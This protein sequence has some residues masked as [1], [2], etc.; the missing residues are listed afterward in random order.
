MPD[1]PQKPAVA[2]KSID[3]AKPFES[4]DL[5]AQKQASSRFIVRMSANGTDWYECPTRSVNFIQRV[6]GKT[7]LS[8]ITTM[9]KPLDVP[10]GAVATFQVIRRSDGS[11]VRGDVFGNVTFSHVAGDSYEFTVSPV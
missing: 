8:F 7:Q 6:S 4:V 5:A 2:A 10:R 3:G 11:Q 1:S 9:K